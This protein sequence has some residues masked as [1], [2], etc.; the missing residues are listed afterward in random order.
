MDAFLYDPSHSRRDSTSIGYHEEYGGEVFHEYDHDDFPWIPEGE[1]ITHGYA[2]SF[3]TEQYDD[4]VFADHV[5]PAINGQ[6]NTWDA[7]DALIEHVDDV[8][9]FGNPRPLGSSWCVLNP[10]YCGPDY[11]NRNQCTN[12]ANLVVAFGRSAG[13]PARPVWVDWRHG[14]FDHSTEIWTPG[15]SGGESAWY[16]GRGYAVNEYYEPESNECSSPYYSGGYVA[17]RST[18]GWYSSGSAQG[19]HAAGANWPWERPGHGG[20]PP[21]QL[22]PRQTAETGKIVKRYWWETRFVPYWSWPAEPQVTGSPPDDWPDPP[23]R[24]TGSSI[25][26]SQPL[27]VTVAD[28]AALA[29]PD[30][31]AIQFGPVVADYGLDPDGDGRYDQLA[32]R[33]QVD[34]AQAGH[35]WFRGQLAGT[36]AE[37][38]G[39]ATLD[40]G[41]HTIELPF[42]GRDIYMNKT[43]GPY[44]LQALWATDVE[45]PTPADWADR[46]LA[47]A[48]PG[49][50]TRAYRYAEFGVAGAALARPDTAAPI[51]YRAVDT[52]GDGYADALVIE[53][54]LDIA[55]PGTYTV[56]G[57]LSSD[58]GRAPAVATWT[59][60]GSKVTLQFAGLRDTVGPYT[61]LGLRVSDAAGQVTDGLRDPFVIDS[62]PEL[63]AKPV[64][65]GDASYCAWDRRC[66]SNACR[67]QLGDQRHRVHGRGPG[68]RWGWPVRP[69]GRH[70]CRTGG[71]GRG[72]SGLPARGM[73]GGRERF[74]RG[75]GDRRAA[76]VGRGPPEP[77][78]G[79]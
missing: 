11:D 36:R 37:A 9:C 75:V 27:T 59:G 1:W 35:Y 71:A 16:V 65:L 46:A 24:A 20:I 72:Q 73:V 14:T 33:I 29:G 3:D 17:L 74:P 60:S 42:S 49:Y 48:S 26:D 66:R 19:V 67:A 5:M 50:V 51:T 56:Q 47:Y 18:K 13:I 15:A 53:T 58:E 76:S 64:L 10:S 7:G 68:Q 25:S 45:N 62:I 12:I 32:F 6:T 40:R 44:T 61:L 21:G 43:D 28:E 8:T 77:G 30:A 22:G 78:A 63:S 79:L 39:D 31:P 2:W 38:V 52:D 69:T 41:Q 34:V 55:R 23:S 54:D 4:F 70:S 57:V